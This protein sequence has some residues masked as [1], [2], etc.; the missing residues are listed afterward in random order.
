[1]IPL[2]KPRPPHA[3]PIPWHSPP[4]RGT[5]PLTSSF[6]PSARSGRHEQSPERRGVI[7][8]RCQVGFREARGAPIS[9]RDVSGETRGAR[10]GHRRATTAARGQGRVSAG[11]LT[12]RVRRGT[13]P[14]KRRA[15]KPTSIAC[16]TGPPA[17]LSPPPP[18]AALVSC[19]PPHL[20]PCRRRPEA[21]RERCAD[22][23]SL[24]KLTNLV[25]RVSVAV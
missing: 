12:K 18:A 3:P 14:R 23:R 21:H 2:P 4:T 10:R 25:N 1:M 6:P 11:T 15:R 22:P 8:Q 19:G 20:V 13:F 17:S 9:A 24:A 16:L 7:W 5:C